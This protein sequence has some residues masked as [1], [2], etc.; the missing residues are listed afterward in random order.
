M[1]VGN[2]L[3]VVCGLFRAEVWPQ[4]DDVYDEWI[5]KRISGMTRLPQRPVSGIFSKDDL[6]KMMNRRSEHKDLMQIPID[7]TKNKDGIRLFT[8]AH[9]DL[10][11]I[12]ESHRS[13]LRNTGR[14]RAF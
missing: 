3:C 4:T 10:I 6:Q 1:L 9:F 7:D 13:I 5:L 14:F 2:R 8:P 12:D 11:I